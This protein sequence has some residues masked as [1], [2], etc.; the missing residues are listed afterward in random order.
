[1]KK[2]KTYYKRIDA[3]ESKKME[4]N[5]NEKSKIENFVKD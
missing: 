1:M 2:E 5:Y 3:N 4:Q